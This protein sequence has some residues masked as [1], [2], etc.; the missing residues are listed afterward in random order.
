MK[1]NEENGVAFM[2]A[3]KSIRENTWYT[4]AATISDNGTIAE[5][6]DINGNILESALTKDA[7]NISELGILITNSTDK[8]IAFRDL[9]IETLNKPVQPL[10]YNINPAN[11][12]GLPTPY[13]NLAIVLSSTF[14]AVVYVWKRK[15]T[16]SRP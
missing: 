1:Q 9:K 6:R 16:P 12:G 3:S 11:E 14:A 10:D 15:K 8:A 2:N 4:I 7:A 5:I 13:I